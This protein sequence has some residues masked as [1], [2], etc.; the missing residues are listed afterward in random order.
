MAKRKQ[1]SQQLRV[2]FGHD[3]RW[4]RTP[5]RFGHIRVFK[6][7][8]KQPWNWHWRAGNGRIQGH[9]EGHSTRRDA[10]R[11]AHDFIRNILGA[12]A[13]A[14]SIAAMIRGGKPRK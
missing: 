11:A 5:Q 8:G 10:Y 7:R 14:G 4:R 13:E 3:A 12:W 1:Y 6:G 2:F 9:G